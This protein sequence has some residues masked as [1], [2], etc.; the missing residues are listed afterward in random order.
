M[1]I[2]DIVPAKDELVGGGGK[3]RYD[4]VCIFAGNVMKKLEEL[5]E[6]NFRRI[7]LMGISF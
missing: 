3:I 2:P 7:F 4:T 1:T 6:T 5:D